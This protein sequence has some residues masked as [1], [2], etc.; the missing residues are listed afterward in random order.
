MMFYSIIFIQILDAN[1]ALINKKKKKKSI[2]PRRKQRS[3]CHLKR[4]IND[5]AM[6]IRAA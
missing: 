1:L 4:V 2:L 3:L 6:L 5:K